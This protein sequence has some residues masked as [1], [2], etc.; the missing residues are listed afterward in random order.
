ME[1][2]ET[3]EDKEYKGKEGKVRKILADYKYAVALDAKWEREAREDIE[4]ALGDQWDTESKKTLKDQGR[5]ILTFNIIGPKINLVSGYQRDNRSTIRAYPEGGEDQLKSDIVTKLLKHVQKM[6]DADQKVSFVFEDGIQIGRGYLEPFIDHTHDL[7]N[8]E[9]KFRQADPFAW[10]I[11]PASIEY[12]L[13]DCRYLVKASLVNKSELASMFPDKPNSFWDKLTPNTND[14]EQRPESILE[15]TEDSTY[16]KVA[17][18]EQVA[19]EEDSEP[20]YEVIEYH[21]KKFVKQYIAVDPAAQKFQSF[22]TRADAEKYLG[23]LRSIFPVDQA[24]PEGQVIVRSVPEFWV[25]HV[26]S[27][28]VIEDKV[29]TFY[30]E[31]RSYPVIPYFSFYSPT[32]KRGLKRNELA[33]QGMVRAMK[34]P[35]REKNKRRS[36][37]LHILNTTANSGWLSVANAWVDPEKVRTLG[38]AAG[39]TLEYNEGKEKPERIQPGG[40]SQGHLAAEQQAEEDA[41]LVTGIN[42]DLLAIQDK[43][44]SGRAIALRQQQGMMMLRRAFDNFSTTKRI[45]G[46]FVLSQLN[47]LFTLDK[48]KKILGE[49]FLMKN[50][51]QDPLNGE[52][53]PVPDEVILDCLKSIESNE[54]DVEIGEGQDSPTV[55][56]SNYTQIEE[57]AQKGIMVPPNIMV[58]YSDIPDS[59]KK[60]IIQANQMMAAQVPPQT[61]QQSPAR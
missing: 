18:M 33:Y 52:I 40:V 27:K 59:A 48:A 4:F 20:L 10:K 16:K 17:Q 41:K 37:F 56:Y 8:G 51:Q 43:T 9:L 61:P 2:L 49:E 1:Y 24:A 25:C 44:T 55:R 14:A 21:Y 35:Q 22:S 42:D 28:E 15:D 30:P 3:S 45:L 46:R 57:M 36:Q 34:D 13:S 19:M 5:P 50:G 6:S 7:I 11:D 53:Y 12:D 58:E 26:C 29:S 47:S 39:V 23:E 32:A 31:W 38:S 54:F 60:E